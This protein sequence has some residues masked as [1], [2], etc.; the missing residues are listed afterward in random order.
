MNR[1]TWPHP[2]LDPQTHLIPALQSFWPSF[3]KYFEKKSFTSLQAYQS[4]YQDADPMHSAIAIVGVISFYVWFMEK[5][6][7][8]ASQVDGLWTFLPLIYSFH[9]TFQKYFSYQPATLH[10]FGGVKHASFWDKV[11]PRLALM[12]ALELLW[13]IRLTYNAI[14]RG[15]FKP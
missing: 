5:L 11:E 7:G 9:F 3:V 2:A 10:L 4:Y 6:T 13:C 15:M 14:R 8:N 1:I 12:S